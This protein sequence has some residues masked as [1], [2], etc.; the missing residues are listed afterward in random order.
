[1]PPLHGKIALITGGSRGIGLAIAQH[2]ARLGASTILLSKGHFGPTRVDVLVNCAGVSQAS[3][4]AR[5][6]LEDI[7]KILDINLKSAVLGCKFIGRQ[8]MRGVKLSGRGEGWGG[9]GPSII[10]VSSV[11]AM[12]GGTGAAV[13]AAT[14]AGLLG[15]TS[16]L[17]TELGQYGIRVNALVPGYIETDMIQ[18]D[19]ITPVPPYFPPMMLLQQQPVPNCAV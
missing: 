4:L 17:S 18:K 16:A 15:L 8:M 1:M 13:Y 14:K 7:E 11:M 19:P 5:T 9:D 6:T 2:F 10:N 3:L 12:R